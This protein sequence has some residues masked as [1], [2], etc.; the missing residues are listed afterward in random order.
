[1]A[2]QDGGPFEAGLARG[3]GR[4]L[5]E[6]ELLVEETRG[7]V[8]PFQELAELDEVPA[9]RMRHGRVGD[10]VEQAGELADALE[11]VVAVVLEGPHRLRAEAPE[12]DAV[13]LL[14]H[15]GGD[16]LAHGPG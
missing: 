11:E 5:H 1:A 9:V 10:A 14:P 8:R 6:V 2:P 4:A 13:E 3:L 12:V 16:L 7:L 15:L